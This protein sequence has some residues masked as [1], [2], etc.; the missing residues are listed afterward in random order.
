MTQEKLAT[1]A[2]NILYKYGQQGLDAARKTVNQQTIPHQPL[3]E[4]T[5]YF[6][7][8]FEDVLHPALLA[9][10]CEAVGGKTQ[11]TVEVGAALV[12]LAGGA[13]LHDDIIDG[14]TVKDGKPTVLG[15]YGKDLTVLA[16][17]ALLFEGFYLLQKACE[18]FSATQ[19]QAINGSH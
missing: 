2:T 12:L 9:L 1:Q 10:A 7:A 14:S 6:M 4:A 18:T 8:C 19:R 15:K 11:D 13:D 17:D 3:Q 16:G 5:Q